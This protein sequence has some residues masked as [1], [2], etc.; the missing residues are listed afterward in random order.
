MADTVTTFL[1]LVKPEVG[2]SS[3]TWGDKINADMDVLDTFASNTLAWKRALGGSENLNS[4]TDYGIYPQNTNA[5]ATGGANY[6]VD[7]AGTLVVIP[8]KSANNT[9]IQLYSEFDGGR[10][11]YRQCRTGSTWSTWRAFAYTADID[12]IPIVTTSTAG[13]MSAGDKVKINGIEAGAQVNPAFGSAAGTACEGND[14]RLS[15]S[16]EWTATTISQAEAEAGTATTRRAFTAQRVKQAIAAIA[17]TVVPPPPVG[18]YTGSNQHETNFPIGHH[19]LVSNGT[20]L[21]N[22]S[23]GTLYVSNASPIK[24]YTWAFGSGAYPIAGTWAARGAFTTSA[25]LAQRVA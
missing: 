20:F 25:Q 2:A 19:V 16:R 14:A 9:A 8:G 1:G 15:D 10:L 6:P 21:N 3:N 12:A 23:S 11:W 17:P 24:T 7:K 13:L 4:I 5:G 22:N 18:L